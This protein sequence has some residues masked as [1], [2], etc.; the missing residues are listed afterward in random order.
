MYKS[1]AL[2]LMLSAYELRNASADMYLFYSYVMFVVIINESGLQT[3]C[4][5]YNRVHECEICALRT[6]SLYK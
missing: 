1:F 3:A 4:I 5:S 6:V 2:Q